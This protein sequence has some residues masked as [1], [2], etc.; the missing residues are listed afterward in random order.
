MSFIIGCVLN[1]LVL[2]VVV[3][4]NFRRND[5]AKI[6]PFYSGGLLTYAVFGALTVGLSLQEQKTWSDGKRFL[7]FL[8]VGSLIVMAGFAA[9]W[10]LKSRRAV[11]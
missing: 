8:T 3:I 11:R 1:L 9:S 7:G 5:R 10:L 2:P 4:L 6:T